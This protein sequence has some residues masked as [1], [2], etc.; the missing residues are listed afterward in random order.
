MV[1]LYVRKINE[2]TMTI[3]DVPV[4]WREKVRLALESQNTTAT[5]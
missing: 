5:E 3:D 1:A 2:G 4:L